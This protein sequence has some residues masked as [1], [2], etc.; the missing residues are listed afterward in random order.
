MH[1]SFKLFLLLP[2]LLTV[3]CSVLE[4][5]NAQTLDSSN[6]VF[7]AKM[8]TPA[9]ASQ[10]K[11]YVD[12]NLRVL[13]H[14][15]D[16][17]SIFNKN[18]YNQEYRFTG[19]TG[20]N[21]GSFEK[22]PVEDF[23]TANPLDN[24]YSIYPYRNTTEISNQGRISVE[25]PATQSYAQNSFGPGVNTMVS[26]SSDN[27]LMYRNV[28]GYLV[29]KLY[30]D[31]VNVSSISIIGNNN[32]KLAGKAYVSI[33]SSDGIPF[34]ELSEEGTN[35]VTLVCD[36][37]VKIGTTLEDYTEF[38][39]VLPP[40]VFS[41]GFTI[42]IQDSN[43]GPWTFKKSTSGE[44][45]INRNSITHMAALDI[46]LSS[47]NRGYAS[48]EDKQFKTFCI[49]NYDNDGDGEI[50]Y[51]EAGMVEEMDVAMK[52]ISSLKG[53][54]F[55]YN[56]SQ[57]KCMFGNL[58]KLDVSYNSKLRMLDCRYNK[59]SSLDVSKN[60]ALKELDCHSNQLTN[61]DVSKN[62]ALKEL[63]CGRNQLTNLDVSKN[64]ALE[65]LECYCN[66]LTSLDVSKNTALKELDCA[67]LLTDDG[68]Y[69][70]HGKLSYL[71]ISGCAQ[72]E[73]IWCDSNGENL[74]E[75]IGLNDCKSLKQFIGYYNDF[76]ELDF[77]GNTEL[78]VL[79][80]AGNINL[81]VLNIT[82]CSE[83]SWMSIWNCQKLSAV[84]LSQNTSLDELYITH[85]Q[86]P[87]FS[88]NTSL[89]FLQIGW[90][91]SEYTIDF[92]PLVNLKQLAIWD[93]Q[94]LDLS[95]NVNIEKLC[96]GSNRCTELDLSSLV[97]L[98]YLEIASWTAIESLDISKNLKLSFYTSAG[99]SSL[100][101]LMVSPYQVIE[102]VTV[103][104]SDEH[105]HPDTEIIVTNA[106]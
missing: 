79:Y 17:V 7:Y 83:L 75:I 23:I 103:N 22:I 98:E 18:S 72:L 66:E 40:V 97:N 34:V 33:P 43:S 13:W 25:L 9:E 4:E 82:K 99:C 52:D 91:S 100:K 86:D 74:S 58:E 36:T 68:G 51:E 55:F 105:I 8:E 85:I 81:E 38:W 10:T 39:F 19:E 63:D 64:T 28:C 30:G 14:K 3:S 56:L 15:N 1:T 69:S 5:D 45:V 106:G 21:A 61:L 54:E 27:M 11:V 2:L 35:Q 93:C 65:N 44:V 67:G 80:L 6:D 78:Q 102:G 41:N 59:L 76:R 60:T 92:S 62:T 47:D 16:C 12:E 37:P 57:L 88:A 73:K 96:I 94:S 48:F 84:D 42:C 87:D 70:P 71:N 32:E 29:L 90:P 95:K 31:D 50:S 49:S 20:A 101:V 77:S 89:S 46:C 24:I 26:V 104:R 53:I